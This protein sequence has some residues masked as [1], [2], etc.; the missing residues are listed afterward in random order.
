MFKSCDMFWRPTP[1]FR[2]PKMLQKEVAADTIAEGEDSDFA[3]SREPTKESPVIPRAPDG[4]NSND[5]SPVHH[6]RTV[7]GQSPTEP[8]GNNS[9]HFPSGPRTGSSTASQPVARLTAPAFPIHR[10]RARANSEKK[11]TV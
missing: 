7:A 3:V 1:G 9:F 11:K 8:R 4:A 10:G 2:L 6:R 5:P